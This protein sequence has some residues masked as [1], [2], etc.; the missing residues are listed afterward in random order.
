MAKQ[1]TII[2]GKGGT[3]KTTIAC[4]L[5]YL[6]AGQA[7]IADVDVDAPDMHLLLDPE[8]LTHE[9]LFVSKKAVR[10][11]DKCT[12]CNICGEVCNYG[13]IT[14]D[15]FDYY[16]CEGCGLC[17]RK[18]PEQALELKQV[19]SAAVFESNT[20][21]GKFVHAEMVIGEGNSGR[22]VD[23]V[24]SKANKLAAKDKAIEYI[25]ID[26]SP[27]IGCPV[28]ASITNV[29]LVLIVIEPT[30]SGIHDLK[31]VLGITDHFK[32][33]P[34]VCINK[35]DI[36]KE[37]SD[38]IAQYCQENNVELMGKIPYNEIVTKSIVQ[39]KTIFELPES[40]VSE[41]IRKIWSKIKE[42]LSTC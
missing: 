12:K 27:G 6:S 14:A 35:Y 26:G 11:E 31:R 13:A 39:Q 41:E 42:M 29:D 40:D 1:L 7:I 23:A 36:N 9:D 20:R 3:G 21:F 19:K 38:K 5:S 8:K 37:N 32:V 34:L 33:T 30:L 22:I 16:K 17:V 28:I 10:N 15:T 24:R 25:I 2:S 18:C 4:A